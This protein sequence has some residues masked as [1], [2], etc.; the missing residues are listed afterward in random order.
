MKQTINKYQFR[1]AFMSIRPDNFSYEALEILFEYFEQLEDDIGE[2]IELD[3]IA[4]CCDWTESTPN[5]IR[6]DYDLADI[7]DDSDLEDYL[8]EQTQLAGI[9]STGNFVYMSF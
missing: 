2:D 4:I 6:Q 8:A 9:T 1:D 7:D 5:D 3:V